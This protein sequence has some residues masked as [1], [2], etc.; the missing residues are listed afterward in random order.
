M[1]NDWHS[2]KCRQTLGPFQKMRVC[3]DPAMMIAA[4]VACANIRILG[5]GRRIHG[6][7]G[8]SQALSPILLE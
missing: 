4:S 3:L 1:D 7:D 6:S 8:R 5:L 2:K